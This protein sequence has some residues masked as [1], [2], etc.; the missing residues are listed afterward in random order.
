MIR[1][2]H[3]TFPSYAALA[4]MAGITDLPFRRLCQ[5]MGAGLVV[6]E[7]IHS[8]PSLRT[9][10]KTVLRS[11]FDKKIHVR[12]IQIVGSDP[13]FLA[14]AARYN[15]QKG[16]E[17]IDIN[18]GCPAKKVLKKAAGSALLSN[19]KLVAEILCSVVSATSVPITLKFRTGPEP[20]N[21]NGVRI[22][23]IAEDCGISALAVH[24]RT[25]KCGF[26]GQAEYQTIAEI[27]DA[28]KIPVFANG[29]IDSPE[30]AKSIMSITGACGVMLGRA[31]HGRPWL[32]GQIDQFLKTG[33]TP[34][35]PSF[36]TKIRIIE[37]HIRRIH[38]F[39]GD[40]FGVKLARK[41]VAWYFKDFSATKCHRKYFNT[42]N[43]AS[44]Q[45]DALRHFAEIRANVGHAA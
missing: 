14:E 37:K 12:A 16:A 9:S 36:E 8:H 10:R 23:R 22:A 40:Y 3:L 35:D 29:D 5:D 25:R 1:I 2:G 43:E 11:T 4:P 45:L 17:L 21:R 41:H 30:K 44:Q 27:V 39:Y 34:P 32:C 13:T 38:A 18:M 24:G 26:K 15:Q 7:M 42:L 6:G 19:E 20:A 28:V 31:T 33:K